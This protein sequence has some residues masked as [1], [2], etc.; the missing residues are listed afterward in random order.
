MLRSSTWGVF[1]ALFF[2]IGIAGCG[3]L[4]P[5]TIGFNS[6]S[7]LNN[8]EIPLPRASGL[9]AL[10]KKQPRGWFLNTTHASVSSSGVVQYLYVANQTNNDIDIFL[11]KGRRTLPIGQISSGIA[12]P[13]GL[14]VDSQHALYVANQL[15]NTV[16]KY[17]YGSTSPAATY[18]EDLDRPLYPLVDKHGNL[19]VGNARHGTVVEYLAGST[20]PYQVLQT[21]GNEADG[22]DFDAQGN[23][24]VAFRARELGSVEVFAPN[25]TQGTVLGMKLDQPQGLVV[26]N[27]GNILVVETGYTRCVDVFTPGSLTPSLQERSRYTGTQLA[28]DKKELEIFLSTLN[29]IVY[30]APYPLAGV[31]PYGHIKDEEAPSE[32]IEGITI[33]DIHP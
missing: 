28:L 9:P 33:T 7:S 3:G 6:S 8:S 23:L 12:A 14:Y 21:P 4:Q 10:P 29:G 25:S 20:T 1:V 26:D 24:Y 31:K 18:S 32:I 15:A 17:A 13:Y 2:A 22:M 27:D 11:E 5:S 30:G 19:F 16:T